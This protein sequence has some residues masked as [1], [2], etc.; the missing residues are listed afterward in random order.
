[1]VIIGIVMTV[2]VVCGSV[3]SSQTEMDLPSIISYDPHPQPSLHKN[4]LSFCG[5]SCYD[6]V[7]T[8]ASVFLP[9]PLPEAVMIKALNVRESNIGGLVEGRS[10]GLLSWWDAHSA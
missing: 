1:M 2:S 6:A 7:V 3:K 8:S 5:P 10:G 9:P 4:C